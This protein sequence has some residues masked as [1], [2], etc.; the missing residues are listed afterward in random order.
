[1]RRITLLAAAVALSVP[2]LGHAAATDA[3][4][5]RLSAL[6]RLVE[7][8]TAQLA[9]QQTQLEQAQQALA[10]ARQ[11]NDQTR[12]ELRSLTAELDPELAMTTARG[13]SASPAPPTSDA[14]VAQAANASP[15]APVRVGEA[16]SKQDPISQ[17]VLPQ[18]VNVLTPPG[19]IL[20]D[21]AVSYVQSGANLLVFR[22]IE[23]VPGVQIGAID[24][25]TTTRNQ[26]VGMV[27]A[28]Y[29]VFRRAEIEL[30]VPLVYGNSRVTEVSQRN[31]QV[32]QT[33][34]LNGSGFGDLEVTGRYQLNSGAD[35]GPITVA[36]LR[37]KPPTGKG[38][39]DLTY[40]FAGA[41]S[42]LATGSGFWGLEPSISTIITSDPVIIFASAGFLYNAPRTTNKTIGQALVGRVDPGDSVNVSLGFALALNPQFNVSFGF[43]NSYIFQTKTE[44]NGVDQ[45]SQSLEVGALLFGMSYR[46]SAKTTIAGNF[47]FGVTSDAPNLTAT[48]R[49]PLLF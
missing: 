43:R 12:A 14:S 41:T 2:S 32:T 19:R 39:F 18:G 35:G 11:V 1:M 6:E 33:T 23:I 15:P 37:I 34:S 40:D 25:N 47:E 45:K 29:G 7:Q 3:N 28:R 31:Q 48:L 42:E 44:L 16:P 17:A 10:V 38:P 26:T 24:A 9:V 30:L 21:T 8:Q 5:P 20:L 22:G 13:V 49:I 36:N 4:D 27:T 46:V